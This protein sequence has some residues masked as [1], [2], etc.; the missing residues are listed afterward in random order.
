ML[1][2][3][4]IRYAVRGFRKSPAFTAAALAALG[5]GMGAATAIFSVVDNALLKAVPFP[6]PDRLAVLWE[7]N[8]SATPPKVMVAPANFLG[9]QQQARC[10][11]SMAAIRDL[12]L[13]LIAGPNGRIEPEEIKA[14][15]V[16]ASLFPVLGIEPVLGRAFR[17]EEDRPGHD[18]VVLLSYDVWVRRFAGDRK[19]LGKNVQLGYRTYTVVGIL[20][21]R[22][23]V[24]EPQVEAWVPLALETT[25][26]HVLNMRMLKVVARLRP[27]DTLDAARQELAAVGKRLEEDNPALDKGY[28]PAAYTMREQ[29]VG[30]VEEP[31]LVIAAAVGLLLLMS[32]ANVANLLLARG[33]GRQKEIAAR[34][35]LGASRGRLIRQFLIEGLVLALAGGA[36]GILLAGAGVAWLSRLGSETLPSLANAAPD[37]RLFA[38]ALVISTFCGVIFGMAPAAQ[39]SSRRLNAALT[40]TA[41]GGTMSRSG[42]RLRNALVVSEIAIALL[43]LVGAGLLLRSFLGLRSY[44]PGYHSQGVLTLRIPMNAGNAAAQRRVAFLGLLLDRL[45]VLPGVRGAAAVN[46]L[47]LT[48]IDPG[49]P[50]TVADRPPL[51]LSEHPWAILRATTPYYFHTMGIPMLAGRDFTAAD[52]AD[53]PPVIIVDKVLADRFWPGGPA[54]ALGGRISI[55]V[56]TAGRVG[57]I[58]GVVGSVRPNSLEPDHIAHQWPTIYNPYP[59]TPFSTMA[60]AVGTEN[61]P[62]S[63]ASA[64]ERQ[65]HA[66]DPE[67]PVMNIRSMD[68]IADSALAAPRFNSF[69][70]IAFAGIA[71]VLATVGIYGV[72]AYDVSQRVH[73]MGIRMALGAQDGDILRLVLGQAASMAACGIAIGLAAALFASRFL[74]KMLY[75]VKPTDVY[76]FAG[77]PLA[78]GAVAIAASYLPSRRA[79]RLDPMEALRHE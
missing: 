40:A 10:F 26:V 27:G 49:T 16:S 66:L 1:S 47:P 79:M 46:A 52:T 31:L 21:P 62:R 4:E 58:V 57:E 17:P 3:G 20:P 29:I 78:L 43:V 35:A 75:A 53:S 73:E 34:M 9:W 61:D 70:L 69:V 2:V 54:A 12:P 42:R 77:V 48:D 64:V 39:I 11:E 65:I 71:F 38:F 41:R 56:A 24:L 72:I 14:E 63:L 28:E 51:P 45:S 44:H 22:F 36:L 6:Q 18:N 8:P 30:R 13:N 33:A 37:L 19:I 7:N 67:R 25:N 60:V 50:F 32:C 76:T 59:Q 5:V 74:E 23:T 68:N 15:M 55:D